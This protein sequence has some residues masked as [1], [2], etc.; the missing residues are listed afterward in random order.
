TEIQV[1]E[2]RV[3]QARTDAVR[4]ELTQNAENA[5]LRATTIEKTIRDLGGFP[6]VIGPFLGR[7]TAAVKA[8]TEQAEPFDEA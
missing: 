8:L 2:T 3:A 5:R 1:A 7:A 4:R 6:D